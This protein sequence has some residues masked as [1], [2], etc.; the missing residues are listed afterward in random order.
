MLS[1]LG[2]VASA[3]PAAAGSAMIGYKIGGLP[4]ALAASAG[5]LAGAYF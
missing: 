4:G 5:T 2:Q 3:L 1:G